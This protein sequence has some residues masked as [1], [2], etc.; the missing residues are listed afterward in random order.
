MTMVGFLGVDVFDVLDTVVVLKLTTVPSSGFKVTLDESMGAHTIGVTKL[1]VVLVAFVDVE[2]VVVAVLGAVMLLIYD[3][4]ESL[5]ASTAKFFISDSIDG[6]VAVA[7]VAVAVVVFVVVVEGVVEVGLVIELVLLVTVVVGVEL[8]VGDTTV[9]VAVLVVVGVVL[10]V[11]IVFGTVAL[12]LTT[13]PSSGFKV[14]LDESMGAHTI[15]VLV[16]L[17]E[18]VG[19]P[20]LP[21]VV[22]VVLPGV[23]VVV[24]V[25]VVLGAVILLIYAK[26]ES[27]AAS[28]ATFFISDSIEGLVVVVVLPGVDVVV[29][30]RLV[31]VVVVVVGF[32]LGAVMLLIYAKIESL[33]AST[34]KFCISD[35]IDGVVVVVEFVAF[36][37]VDDGTTVVVGLV[38]LAGTTGLTWL[39]LVFVGV[40]PAGVLG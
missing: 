9:V 24:V 26:I 25:G 8:D 23:D 3:K 4:I 36:E 2:V 29:V 40:N 12:K 38:P 34:A 30:V 1:D 13:V 10:G 15:G 20:V 6:V 32:V 18:P 7:A 28:T 19:V 14:T 21:G 31:V 17:V 35:S 37:G 22:V 39:V 33:A 11:V 16:V 5:A 27:L